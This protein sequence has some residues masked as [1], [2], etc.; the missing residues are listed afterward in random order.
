MTFSTN[1]LDRD[2][3]SIC[4]GCWN[5]DDGRYGNC[6]K[7]IIFSALQQ[8]ERPILWDY[9]NMCSNRDKMCDMHSFSVHAHC[10][11]LQKFSSGV[12]MSVAVNICEVR[13]LSGCLAF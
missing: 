13:V 6:R 1:S 10:G 5:A 4:S 3:E 11:H 12:R 2:D 9:F 8:A 7:D